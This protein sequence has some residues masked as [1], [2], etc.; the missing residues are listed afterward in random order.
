MRWSRFVGSPA[1]LAI[2]SARVVLAGGESER[3]GGWIGLDA[4]TGET[5]WRSQVSGAKGPAVSENGDLVFA[6]QT[7]Q[8]VAVGTIDGRVAWR[9]NLAVEVGAPAFADG[10]LYVVENGPHP[11][12]LF[13]LDASHGGILE[14]IDPDPFDDGG[15]CGPAAAA[16]GMLFVFGCSGYLYAF[17]VE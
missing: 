7:A 9:T 2:T 16:D 1:W 17:E 10:R 15:F 8:C 14:R 4:G 11:R 13:T 6:C 12:S 5:L 3:E